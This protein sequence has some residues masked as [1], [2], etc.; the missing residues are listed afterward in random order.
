MEAA[1]NSKEGLSVYYNT[2]CINLFM[3]PGDTGYLLV[4]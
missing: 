3:V 1:S 4:V 2:V